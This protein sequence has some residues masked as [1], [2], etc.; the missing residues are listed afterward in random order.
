MPESQIEF[1][2]KAP[3]ESVWG[4]IADWAKGRISSTV[5]DSICQI[6]PFPRLWHPFPGRLYP[7]YHTVNNLKRKIF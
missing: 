7:T 3:I 4:L 1:E 6:K 5:Q 2:V